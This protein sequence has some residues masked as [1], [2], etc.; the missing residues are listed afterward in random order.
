MRAIFICHKSQGKEFI[1][2][3]INRKGKFN[4]KDHLKKII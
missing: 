1:D 2:G 4:I 3:I